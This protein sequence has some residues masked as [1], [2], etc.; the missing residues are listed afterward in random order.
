MMQFF[1]VSHWAGARMTLMAGAVALLVASCGQQA[2]EEAAAS[3]APVPAAVTERQEGYKALGASFKVINDQLKTDAPDMAQ[4]IPAAERMNALASQIPTW[5][6]AGTGPQDGVKTDAL[7][8]VWTDP[9]GFAAAQARLAE[10]TTRLQELAM[11][12]DVAGL[13]EH[14]RVVGASC[15][16][17]HD[18]YRVEQ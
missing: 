11:A 9:E 8:T 12:G 5:F 1:S 17:C 14:V 13:R 15:G 3:D 6:P 2:G 10:A 16:G 7:A 18:N 4:I